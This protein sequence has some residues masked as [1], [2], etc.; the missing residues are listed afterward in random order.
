MSAN[1]PSASPS[2]ESVLSENSKLSTN[3]RCHAFQDDALGHSDACELVERLQAKAVSPQELAEAAIARAQQVQPVLHTVLAERYDDGRKARVGA[4][5]YF[6]GI[7]SFIKDNLAV[8]GLPTSF[9]SAAFDAR[10]ERRHDPYADQYLQLGF[11]LL[12]KSS[13]PEFGFNATTEPAHASATPN[14]WQLDYSAGASS[15]GAG[16]LVAAGVVPLAHGNDGGGSIRIPASACGLVGLKPSRDRHRRP[17]AAKALPINIISEGVLTRSVRDTARFHFEAEK[18]YRNPRLP[19]LPLVLG[20]SSKRLKIGLIMDSPAGGGS[21][22]DTSA[23]LFES[24]RVLQGLGHQIKEIPFPVPL[25]FAEHF[26]RYWAMM[27]YLVKKAGPRAFKNFEA[28]KL[29]GLTLG[30]SAYYAKQAYKTPLTLLRL[31]HFSY[32]IRKTFNEVDVI[33]SPTLSQH[34]PKLGYLSPTV[35]F[36]ELFERLR[37]YIGFTPLANVAGTPAISLPAG[38]NSQGLPSSI[39]FMADVGNEAQLLALAYEWEQAQPWQHLWQAA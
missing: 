23:A 3:K 21:D 5:G 10:Q 7:P 18:V 33:L 20:P 16:A 38:F 9:G 17:V 31:K 19:A 1:T 4:Q 29:D 12:G 2:S 32:Q 6:S 15:G 39:Q 28:I 25:S 27:A 30:L 8:A 11:N 26:A 24:T 14:P 34:T 22:A 13:L 36:D 35:E 37:A